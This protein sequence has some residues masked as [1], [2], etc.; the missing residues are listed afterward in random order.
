MR[1]YLSAVKTL[2]LAEL[3]LCW[4]HELTYQSVTKK[5]YGS[6]Y[7]F[8][9]NHILPWRKRQEVLSELAVYQWHKKT[10]E[11]VSNSLTATQ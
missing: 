7:P 8:P 9:L 5:R 11:D 1:T 10:I 2:V 4:A 3:Y 6:V